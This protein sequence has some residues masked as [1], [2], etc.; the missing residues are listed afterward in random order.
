MFFIDFGPVKDFRQIKTIDLKDGDQGT[1]QPS[2]SN[3]PYKSVVL[4][5]G[6]I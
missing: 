3:I 6:L 2:K 4:F 5:L 1:D